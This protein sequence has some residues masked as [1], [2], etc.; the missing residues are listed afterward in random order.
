ML[1]QFMTGLAALSLVGAA[2]AAGPNLA[3]VKAQLETNIPEV[4]VGEVNTT[5][6]PGL[7]EAKINGQLVYLTEDGRY[8]VR[9]DIYD[10]ET[11][12]NLSELSRGKIR[13]EVLK[14]LD[15]DMT[16]AYGPKKAK[17]TLTV[18]TDTSCGYCRKLH[19]EEVPKLTEQG[20]KVRYLLFPRAGM[21]SPGYHELQSI[22]CAKNPQEALTKAKQGQQIPE[23]TC[24]NPIAEHMSLAQTFG[25]RGT[26][27]MVTD[28]G[29][30]INGYRPADQLLE[31]LNSDQQ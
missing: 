12:T 3:K 20:I 22:W 26:P 16:I 10:R 5:P 1:R 27:L 21:D 9:G 31:I 11:S 25:L 24:D 19:N 6:V 13:L 17:H 30:L 23:K 14:E 7:F 8:M 2:Q 18:F 15:D 4:E 28:K 29:M